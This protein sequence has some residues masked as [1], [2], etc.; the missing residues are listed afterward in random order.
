MLCSHYNR[1]LTLGGRFVV[2]TIGI[3]TLGGRFVVIT[4]GIL[5]LGGPI[6]VVTKAP[7]IVALNVGNL[8][9]QFLHF[10]LLEHALVLDGYYL[11]EVLNV[12]MPVVE[13]PACEG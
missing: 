6:V 3:L 1:I 2:I 12:A 7:L 10:L 9:V 4:I 8:L 11:D 5:T 13:H